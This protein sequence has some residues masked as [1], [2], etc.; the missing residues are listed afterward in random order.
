MPRC[1]WLES[2]ACVQAGSWVCSGGTSQVGTTSQ[3]GLGRWAVG[4]LLAGLARQG[5]P[6]KGSA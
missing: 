1:S 6:Y 5:G 4:P 3:A 2:Y